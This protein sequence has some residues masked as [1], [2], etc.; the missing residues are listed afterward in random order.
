ML[1]AVA[2]AVVL[3]LS[4]AGSSPAAVRFELPQTIVLVGA[5]QAAAGHFDVLVRAEPSDLPIQIGSFN[6]DVRTSTAGL[7]FGAP[8]AAPNP[9]LPGMPQDFS[10]NPQTFRAA[11]DVGTSAP[12]VDGAALVR[13]P[14]Q[15]PPG[16][17]GV[18]D[19]TF[20]SINRLFEPDGDSLALSTADVGSITVSLSPAAR[21]DFDA[22]GDA[23]GLDL[24]LWQRGL[25]GTRSGGEL[26][27]WRANFGALVLPSAMPVPE[28]ATFGSLALAVLAIVRQS[29]TRRRANGSHC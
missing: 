1:K 7:T 29:L 4:V 3:A 6:V 8:Q 28:P 26:A 21:G 13:I 23:D 2:F 24:L 16:L 11:L 19:L 15:M 5:A 12:L 17:F 10:P 18:F 27:T 9:L 22:D 25:G 14:F 20:G